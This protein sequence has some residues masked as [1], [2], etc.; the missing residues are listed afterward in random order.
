MAAKRK[1]KQKHAHIYVPP[2][3]L[4]FTVF[5]KPRDFCVLLQQQIRAAEVFPVGSDVQLMKALQAAVYAT[6]SQPLKADERCRSSS[7]MARG[8]LRRAEGAKWLGGWSERL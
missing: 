8:Q 4:E 2:S 5:S 1:K 7:L 3:Y 6:A